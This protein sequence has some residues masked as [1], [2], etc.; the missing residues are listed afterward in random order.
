MFCSRKDKV[1]QTK[2]ANSSQSLYVWMIDQ[3]QDKPFGYRNKSVYR[4]AEYFVLAAFIHSVN[5]LVNIGQDS[6]YREAVPAFSYL[7]R[8][9]HLLFLQRLSTSR[10]L[11]IAPECLPRYYC[12]YI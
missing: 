7:H 3:T 11:K 2:L 1:T 5:P 4:V 8:T 10:H 6:R 9:R 12:R